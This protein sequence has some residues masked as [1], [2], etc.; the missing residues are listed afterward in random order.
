MIEINGL[1]KKFGKKMIFENVSMCF[2]EGHIYGFVGENGVGKSVFFKTISGLIAPTSGEIICNGKIVGKEID[3][4]ENLG[5]MDGEVNF[6]NHLKGFENLKMLASIKSVINDNEI[7][8]FMSE[9][10]L[11]PDDLTLVKDYSLGMKQ[12]LAIIQAV[13]EDPD[14]IIFDE[15]FNGLDKKS[16]VFVKNYILELKKSNKTILLTSHILNDIEEIADTVYEFD[17][18]TIVSAK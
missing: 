14:T 3:Y 7:R 2:E 5:Y 4:I 18:G 17:N 12:K 11:D 13:M 8:A 10:G 9:F 16:C 15:P 1:T 6:I